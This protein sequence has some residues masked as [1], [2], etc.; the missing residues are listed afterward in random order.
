MAHRSVLALWMLHRERL[1][2][3]IAVWRKTF[4][5]S[6]VTQSQW[7]AVMGTRPWSGKEFV[8]EGKDY[9][10]TYISWKDA[11]SFCKKLTEVERRTRRLP[12]GWEYR[13]PTEAPWEYA[14]RAGTTTA[15]GIDD[16]SS[17]RNY[18]WHDGTVKGEEYAHKVGQ[19]RANAYGLH[20]MHGNLWEWCQDYYTEAL[21]GGTD[22]EGPSEGAFR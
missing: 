19:K 14:C 21:P 2:R 3:R 1:W 22:P 17:F 10:A 9:P 5:N 20:D 12:A 6:E 13:L 4:T 18:A 7:Q 11:I 8:R 16:R 15:Y